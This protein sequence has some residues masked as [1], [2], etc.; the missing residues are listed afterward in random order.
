MVGIPDTRR[1][2]LIQALLGIADFAPTQEIDP[3]PRLFSAKLHW[4]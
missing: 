2:H 3:M 4:P 1:N